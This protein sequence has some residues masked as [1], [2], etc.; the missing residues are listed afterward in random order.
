MKRANAVLFSLLMIVTSLAGCIG[1]EDFDSS[2]L[3]QQIAELEK[4]QELMNQTIIAQQNENDELRASLEMMNQTLIA[5]ELLNAEIQ[6]A[7]EDM[8]A[9][10]ANNVQNLLSIISGLQ[11]NISS[12]QTTISSII[13]DL[14]DFNSS[15]SGL[16][17]QLNTTQ[18]Y[19][20]SLESNLNTTIANMIDEIDWTSIQNENDVTLRLPYMDYQMLTLSMRIF[21]VQ[22]FITRISLMPTLAMPT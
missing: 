4:N 3:E 15:N 22:I 9:S 21:M 10:N 14:A 12:V 7:M 16:F 19:L 11:L 6:Q 18:N 17:D 1:G 8:N 5:Q 2:G 13:E 20:A